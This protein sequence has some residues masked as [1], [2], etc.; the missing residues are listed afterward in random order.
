MWCNTKNLLQNIPN[1]IT[2]QQNEIL[3][4]QINENKLKQ[5]IFQMENYKYPGIDGL[6]IEYYKEFYEYLKD[7]LLQLY[8]NI[9]FIE[10]QSLK[11]MNR[12]IITLI[13][14]KSDTNHP[15]LNDLR[16]WKPI[17]LLC[18]DY[19]I[20]TKILANRL[21]NIL[22]NIMSEEQKEQFLTTSF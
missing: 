11:T 14:K 12:A 5:E 10:K 4:K 7:D 15:S 3:I 6:P 2:Q 13:P 9:L 21:Q 16:N 8:N 22:P 19:K 18:I 17:S 20:L 1:K